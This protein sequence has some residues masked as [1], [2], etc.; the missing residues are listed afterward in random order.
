MTA[1]HEDNATPK[2]DVVNIKKVPLPATRSELS[3]KS[4]RSKTINDFV[5][6]VF[7]E[8]FEVDEEYMALI[9]GVSNADS[10]EGNTLDDDVRAAEIIRAKAPMGSPLK[11][12]KTAAIRYAH[13]VV[14]RRYGISRKERREQFELD[15]RYE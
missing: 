3:R 9:D 7:L 12:K 4:L 5:E 1:F 14:L 8:L 10:V 13:G 11:G 6:D 2:G 15:A